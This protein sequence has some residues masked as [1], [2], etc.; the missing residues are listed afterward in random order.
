MMHQQVSTKAKPCMQCIHSQPLQSQK[1]WP[2]LE[3]GLLQPVQT[4]PGGLKHCEVEDMA[5]SNT[6]Q[7]ASAPL[8]KAISAQRIPLKSD[9]LFVNFL[10]F[11][12]L[13]HKTRKAVIHRKQYT[14]IISLLHSKWVFRLASWQHEFLFG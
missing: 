8:M 14:Y 10:F 1:P 2:S 4:E 11:W 7:Q 6:K 9:E 12:L 13:Y 5:A 3:H